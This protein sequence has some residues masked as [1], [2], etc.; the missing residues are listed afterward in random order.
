MEVIN[1]GAAD[2]LPPVPWEIVIE[3]LDARSSPD[4]DAHNARTTWLATINEDGSPHVTT[5]GAIWLDSTFWFQTGADTRKARNVERDQ[6]CSIAVSIRGADVVL[7][8]V[9]ARSPTPAPRRALL[10]RGRTMAGRRRFTT[11]APASL[12]RSTHLRK[13][14]RPGTCTGSSRVQ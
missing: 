11:E 2:G 12:H 4:P 10:R 1:L 6:R 13:D 8:G 7:E 5:V 3:Q 9:A 14:R